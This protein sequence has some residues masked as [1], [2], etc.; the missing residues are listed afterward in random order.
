MLTEWDDF[1]WLDY[2]KVAGVMKHKAIVDARNLLDR[3]VLTRRGFTYQ[4]LGRA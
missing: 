4:G 1:R 3:A 2:D